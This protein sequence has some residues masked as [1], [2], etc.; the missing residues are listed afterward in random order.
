MTAM[1]Q[2]CWQSACADELMQDEHGFI[3]DAM[4]ET[5]DIDLAGKRVLDVGCNRG[6]FLRLLADRCGIVGGSGYD[7]AAGAIDDARRLAGERP[8]QFEAADTV[9]AGWGG[10]DVAFSHEVLYLLHDLSSHAQVIFHALVPGGVYYA[11]TGVRAD[12]PV[13]AEWH[14]ANVEKLAMPKALRH[15]RADCGLLERRIRSCGGAAG[16]AL[17]PR[18]RSRPRSGPAARVARLLLRPEADAPLRLAARVTPAHTASR[19]RAPGASGASVPPAPRSLSS[20]QWA[21][22]C[23]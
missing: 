8:L 3:W 7:P 6:G 10:F 14:R 20:G 15:R 2:T 9:P 12:S 22:G 21:A 4:L 1:S 18:R 17:R 19:D 16:D 13:M 11:V 5:I 23:H